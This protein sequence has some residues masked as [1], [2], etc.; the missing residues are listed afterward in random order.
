LNIFICFKK[1]NYLLNFIKKQK[2]NNYINTAA[3][4]VQRYNILIKINDLIKSPGPLYR[5]ATFFFT[6]SPSQKVAWKWNLFFTLKEDFLHASFTLA[7]S[8]NIT[9]SLVSLFST[10]TLISI[11]FL[12]FFLFKWIKI[13]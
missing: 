8:R 3:S 6:H 11:L 5:H 2:I 7:N 10:K 4:I 9:R 1:L 12:L 13:N